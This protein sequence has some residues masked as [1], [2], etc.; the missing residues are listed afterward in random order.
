M[1]RSLHMGI[2][3]YPG[4][5]SDL[6]GCVNDA[7]AWREALHKRGFEWQD[8]L[9][10][11]KC[12][13][14]AMTDAIADI[15]TA[16]K[17]GDLTVIT[18]SG[19]GTWVPDVDGDEPDGRD[20][21]LCPWDMNEGEVLTDDYLYSIFREVD[22]AARVIFISDSCHS[23]SVARHG[24]RDA[25][26][27]A[28]E[29]WKFQKA[30]FMPPS[31]HLTPEGIKSAYR[32]EKTPPKARS[33]ETPVVLLA[34]CKDDEYSYDAWFQGKPQGA[35]SYVALWTLSRLAEGSTY[36]QWYNAIRT[37]LPVSQYPQTP[38]FDATD[39]QKDWVVF[40]E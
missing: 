39:E 18:Y 12:F 22:P 32:V 6:Q 21:A 17:A 1:R 26:P 4:A 31:F 33:R 3:D 37:Y 19:H 16:T 8:F 5:D 10:N 15:I 30:K 34:G 25:G 23:G 14:K 2:N 40:S 20:E 28:D 11:E 27:F 36:Q 38:Q 9:T 7:L 35:F 24:R 29:P 13:R